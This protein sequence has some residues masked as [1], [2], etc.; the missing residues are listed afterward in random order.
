MGCVCCARAEAGARRVGGQR[1]P[2]HP[3]ELRQRGAARVLPV[4]KG[5][6]RRQQ[7]V[8]HDARRPHVGRGVHLHARGGTNKGVRGGVGAQAQGRAMPSSGLSGLATHG[9]TSYDCGLKAGNH[10][11][12]GRRGRAQGAQ[13]QARALRMLPVAAGARPARW[14][15]A[16]CSTAAGHHTPAAPRKREP[17]RHCH[18]GVSR[19][20]HT[21][22]RPHCCVT[23]R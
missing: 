10:C 14:L 8:C 6:A 15:Q 19:G 18:G 4:I 1:A 16:K 21:A 20:L 9:L 23:H 11:A 13:P 22:Q 17:C 2:L 7:L 12:R 5:E 3:P